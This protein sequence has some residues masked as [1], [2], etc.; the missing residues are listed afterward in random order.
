MTVL[1][2][3]IP[4]PLDFCPWD[5]PGWAY[6]ALE[7]VVGFQ[8]PDGD[9]KATWDAA[10]R[11]FALAGVLAGPRDEATEAA[12]QVMSGYGGAGVTVA[13]FQQAWHN[14]ADGDAPLNSLM[15]ISHELGK[16]IEECG[17]D[18]E[19]AKLEAWIELG[20]F[21]I[22]LIGMAVAVTLTLGAASPAAAGLIAATRFAIQQIFRKLIEQLGKK[23]IKKSLKEAGER[24]AK[25]LTTKAGLKH[26][27]TDALREGLDEA[28]EEGVTNGG[29]QLYQGSTGRSDGLDVRELGMSGV[30]GFAGGFAASGAQVG[31]GGRSSVG[32]ALRGA[33]G[34]VLGEVGGAAAF[35]DLPDLDGVAKAASSGV[36]GSVMHSVKADLGDGLAGLDT[37]GLPFLASDGAGSAGSASVGQ[38]AA[39]G[40]GMDLSVAAPG[41]GSAAELSAGAPGPG[42]AVEVSAAAVGPS[43][44]VEVPAAAVGAASEAELSG[45][46]GPASAPGPSVEPSAGPSL[47][48]LGSPAG[49]D[50]ATGLALES[51]SPAG[52]AS[53]SGSTPATGTGSPS[54]PGF[55]PGLAA[56]PGPPSAFLPGTHSSVPA[57]ELGVG[58]GSGGGFTSGTG[59]GGLE[60][61]QPGGGPGGRPRTDPAGSPRD[62]LSAVPGKERALADRPAQASRDAS[63]DRVAEALAPRPAQA[64]V[65][66]SDLGG[67]VDLLALPAPGPMPAR[68]FDHEAAARAAYFGYLR[69]A[70][71]THEDLRRED[72]AAHLVSAA[73][74][75]HSQAVELSERAGHARLDGLILRADRWFAGSREL[76]DEAADLER[77]AD[78]V[79]SGD[80]MPER[81]DVEGADWA[82]INYDVGDLAA[83][84]V[85]TDD[86]SQL[87]GHDDPPP[88]DRSRRYGIR[89]G[90]RA[91]LTVHQTDLERAMPRDDG[92]RVRRH[93][94][95]RQGHWFGLANDG[96]PEAD[97][98]RGINCLDGVL[99]LFDTYVHGRPRVSAPRTFDCYAAGDP[100][101]PLGA[102]NGGLARI[103]NTV[104][105]QFQG[106]CPYVGATGH[107]RAKQSVDLAMTN[108]GNHLHNLGHGAFAFIVTDSEGGSAHAWTAVNHSGTILFLDPQT[109]RISETVPLYQNRGT[110]SESNIVSMDAL[111]LDSGGQ[112]APLPFHRAGIWSHSA[113]E[114]TGSDPAD[115]EADSDQHDPPGVGYF[116]DL[117]ERMDASTAELGYF[118]SLPADQ[119][120]II[121][122]SVAASDVVADRAQHDLQSAVDSLAGD[123]PMVV[124]AEH[125]TKTPASLARAYLLQQ[126]EEPDL[127]AF[128]GRQKDRVRFSVEVSLD[129]YAETVTATLAALGDGGYETGRIVN[130]WSEKGRHNG[131]NITLTDPTGFRMEVQ[132]PTTLTWTIGKET[133][134]YYETLRLRE[135]PAQL[136]M[137]AFFRILAINKQFGIAEQ[138]PSDLRALGS[139]APVD[140]GLQRWLA[141]ENSLRDEYEAWLT[142]HHLSWSEM[143][144]RHHLSIEDAHGQSGSE[145]EQ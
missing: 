95:P 44:A 143:L 128:L 72:L 118:D 110:P 33:G 35:G 19:G 117:Y 5:L 141:K 88:I 54:G 69:H 12:F 123:R 100:T 6:E 4:H 89:G 145:R 127:E 20:I 130:F 22:E 28:A 124:G 30:G 25:Q 87:T 61:G 42:S 63:I 139:P 77:T 9:E 52:A 144:E 84:P 111:V 97:P 10:D 55:Q 92:G 66:Q 112:F 31:R 133:H 105:G 138:Q 85:E 67:G 83:G 78:R 114:P 73:D 122:Q 27:G 135:L 90:L 71:Q 15:E 36:T 96:G 121:E 14:L 74:R 3:P 103:E 39:A 91:P 32:D 53:P 58:P 132:F 40:P 48:S 104:K 45:A 1:P 24:A 126:D 140:S 109:R 38:S 47:G 62:G 125:R 116:A 18:I 26:L 131:L 86:T 82:R 57:P 81:V 108:L 107:A 51:T 64:E 37:S 94:D 142:E 99:S 46:R 59:A 98:T 13:A 16:M 93:A 17:C 137:D 76:R 56:G 80:L 49:S 134:R 75:R 2:S 50:L 136:R 68:H 113:L 43:S 11:W 8:W 101:R 119:R 70:R 41:P 106:L 29:I 79:R 129:A 21:V 115:G 34:E 102:E 65:R 23:A 120:L 7:W 60:P